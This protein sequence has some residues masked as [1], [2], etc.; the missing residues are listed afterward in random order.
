M[1]GGNERCVNIYVQSAFKQCQ[2]QL[3][4]VSLIL[5]WC[6]NSLMVKLCVSDGWIVVWWMV[7]GNMAVVCCV[8][9]VSEVTLRRP[10]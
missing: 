9:Y 4:E 8:T 6:M 2:R 3:S 10:R 7:I 5:K 1:S